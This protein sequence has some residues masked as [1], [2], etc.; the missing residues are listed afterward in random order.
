MANKW[1]AEFHE[2]G[3]YDC[4]TGAWVIFDQNGT[5]A[6]LDQGD[7]G[8]ENCDYA[9]RSL[10]AEANAKLIVNLYNAQW[11]DKHDR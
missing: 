2:S 4:M 1:K 10:A 11:E 6:T 9:F 8:Q 5:I 7:Y 3:G